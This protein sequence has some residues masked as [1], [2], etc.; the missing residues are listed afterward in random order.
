ML[1]VKNTMEQPKAKGME[2]K[3]LAI[4]EKPSQQS[5][6]HS[7]HLSPDLVYG[8]TLHSARLQWQSVRLVRTDI[9][10]LRQI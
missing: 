7:P 9:Y 4:S 8:A 3:G 1:R 2:K 6:N 5:Q 10:F